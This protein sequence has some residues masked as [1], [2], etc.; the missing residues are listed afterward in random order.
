MEL[1]YLLRVE[2]RLKELTVVQFTLTSQAG[3]ITWGFNS[4][5]LRM[6]EVAKLTMHPLSILPMELQFMVQTHILLM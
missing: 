5:H 1:E 6:A 4:I 2:S 3:A